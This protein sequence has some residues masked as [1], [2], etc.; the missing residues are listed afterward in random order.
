MKRK[1][2]RYREEPGRGK[3]R[4]R[5]REFARLAKV[6]RRRIAYEHFLRDECAEFCN[7]SFDRCFAYETKKGKQKEKEKLVLRVFFP[8]RLGWPSRRPSTR[9]RSTRSNSSF[10][11][12]SNELF[13]TRQRVG[14]CEIN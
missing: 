14:A 5:R 2:D 11:F 1:K 4:A 6:E 10:L 12:F 8:P 9:E 3:I 13:T 7:Y